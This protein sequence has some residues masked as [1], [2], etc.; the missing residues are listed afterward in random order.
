MAKR[1]RIPVAMIRAAES[2][3]TAA[4]TER[5]LEY[6][7]S[8]CENGESWRAASWP[9]LVLFAGEFAGATLKALSEMLPSVSPDVMVQYALDA[10]VPKQVSEQPVASR[11]ATPW[12]TMLGQTWTKARWM[13]S[14]ASPCSELETHPFQLNRWHW[15]TITA[16]VLG[17]LDQR[18]LPVLRANFLTK[19]ALRHLKAAHRRRHL[20]EVIR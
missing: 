1:P 16:R 7:R 14:G 18:Y 4:L 6:W 17:S 5:V 19:K 11:Q 9:D 3:A 8:I 2:R 10:V 13:F 20:P 15:T 12:E